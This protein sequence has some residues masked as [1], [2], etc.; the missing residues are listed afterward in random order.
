[1]VITINRVLTL[2]FQHVGAE[3]S[4]TLR[5]FSSAERARMAADIRTS[6]TDEELWE[7]VYNAVAPK[8]LSLTCPQAVNADGTP[9]QLPEDAAERRQVLG[10]EY[11]FGLQ[12]VLALLQAYNEEVIERVGK[13]DPRS[14][15][16]APG[17]EPPRA[18]TSGTETSATP[19]DAGSPAPGEADPARVETDSSGCGSSTEPSSPVP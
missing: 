10:L 15:A 3:W 12:F 13:S 16:G 2:R 8:L 6:E 4:A 5:M 18:A 1:M 7:A 9:F 17:P 11:P 14:S 19:A